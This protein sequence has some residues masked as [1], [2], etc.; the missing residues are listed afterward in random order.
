VAAGP[1]PY[2]GNVSLSFSKIYTDS[3]GGIS[4]LAPG[5]SLNVGLATVPAALQGAVQRNPSDLGIVAEGSGDVDIY[6]KG[7]VNVN[8]SRIFTLGGGN[9]LIWSDEGNIDA[10]KGA[11]T[12]VSAPPPQISIAANGTITETFFGAVAGS[13]IRTIQALAG[14][15]PGNVNLV[16]PQGSVNAG[17]AGI[18]ASG[19]INIAA[20][21]V[22]G[23]DNIQFGGTATGVPAQVSDIGV[24][25]SGAA[26]LASS[27]T[28][29]ATASSDEEARKNAAATPQAHAAIGWLDVF[30]IGLG[31]ENCAPQDMECLK[32]QK[33][34]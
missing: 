14:V 27:A 19:N 34:E 12:S 23:L 26:S 20:Q 10:G 17:D 5:G 8:A 1:S 11:K 32:R 4:I 18:G 25:L 6:T 16:A 33:K 29:T 15:P 31:E 24:A 2:T 13:G 9:I 7:D 3:G 21:H 30:V 22:I 28:N